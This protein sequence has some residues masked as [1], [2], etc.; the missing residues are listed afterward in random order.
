MK[1]RALSILLALMLALTACATTAS[2][3]KVQ[4]AG[5][6][7]IQ[8]LAIEPGADTA[9]VTLTVA[10]G[11]ALLV[12]VYDADQK[13][14]ALGGR[15]V[16]SGE[17]SVSVA[18]SAPAPQRFQAKAFLLNDSQTP[19][20]E[21]FLLD[22]TAETPT[23]DT[24]SSK[25]LV[26]YF[27]ATGTT[28]GV[29]E[30][31]QTATGGDL[32]EIVPVE[33]YTAADLN[34]N[35]DCRANAEQQ[36]PSA[37]PAIAPDCTV[38]NMADYDVV[39]LG[40]PIWWG[41]PP[42]IMRTFVE[43]YDLSG[44]TVVPFCTSGGSSFSDSGLRDLAPGATWLEG[45][46]FSA[47]VTQDTLTAWLDTLELPKQEEPNMTQITLAFNGHTYPATLADNS[48]A[49]ALVQ[50]IRESGGAMTVHMNEYGGWE[51]VG[52]LGRTLPSSDVQTT[53]A[54]GDF[55]LYSSDQ[56]VLFYGSNSWAYTRLGHI[57]DPSGLREALGDGDVDITFQLA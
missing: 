34:Y 3:P 27:S 52:S 35:T 33:P 14:V 16:T 54:P 37:R 10:E 31:L 2:T 36:D 12:A 45:R 26:A 11:S 43:S 28:K 7:A 46:R 51:K 20:C 55:V 25:T 40:Y 18:L 30:A 41:I 32:F 39:F 49:Q 48:S 9:Q 29:A 19:A 47:G 17:S 6:T 1:K 8:S 53:T 21:S 44:K 23:P 42:K 50:M 22:R 38:A 57:D 13:M 24:P 56:I 15:W 4:A 5:S